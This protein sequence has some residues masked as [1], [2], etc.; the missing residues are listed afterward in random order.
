MFQALA[1]QSDEG[2]VLEMS[3]FLI[4]H[5]GNSTFINSFHET[6]FLIHSS[7]EAAPQFL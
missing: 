2:L 4:F 5:G 1:L 3:A 6:K 7:T